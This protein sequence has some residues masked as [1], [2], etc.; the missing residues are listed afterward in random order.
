MAKTGYTIDGNLS[1]IQQAEQA[2]TNLLKKAT[3]GDF[4]AT[5]LGLF[6]SNL[7]YDD[8]QRLDFIPN[9]YRFSLRMDSPNIAK[10]TSVINLIN[11]NNSSPDLLTGTINLKVDVGDAIL[12]S[13]A[14]TKTDN[15]ITNIS[16][17]STSTDIAEVVLTRGVRNGE[18]AFY[19]PANA[20]AGTSSTIP[21]GFGGNPLSVQPGEANYSPGTGVFTLGT[22]LTY[23]FSNGDIIS[24]IREKGHDTPL[25]TSP[26]SMYPLQISNYA[27]K[28]NGQIQ[29]SLS[30]VRQDETLAGRV[31]SP[32]RFSLNNF[33]KR[34]TNSFVN[35]STAVVNNTPARDYTDLIFQTP[36]ILQF[37][38]QLPV[39]ADN[40]VNWVPPL[41]R[42]QGGPQ[43]SVELQEGLLPGR[44]SYT[45]I[46][47]HFE[48]IST[49]YNLGADRIQVGDS[50]G[51]E[52]AVIAEAY[53]SDNI[54]TYKD[55]L[56]DIESR[57]E[58]AKVI[59]KTRFTTDSPFLN[60]TKDL[61][62]IDGVLVVQDGGIPN[63][64]NSPGTGTIAGY[65]G[66][67][68]CPLGPAVYI[69][70]KGKYNR[71]FSTFDC[72]SD[73]R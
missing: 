17:S 43:T 40:F 33:S 61:I 27:I 22:D 67:D 44:G 35:P 72:C 36:S 10:D 11:A 18:G 63:G 20:G 57:I 15:F 26:A 28:R 66:F 51:D 65:A 13:P 38:R 55:A 71:A 32:V 16:R 69:K 56:D 45:N 21:A 24:A 59:S 9:N 64:K 46:Y 68:D 53:K 41:M 47:E 6:Q 3:N 58:Y 23:A 30:R 70:E 37:T 12:S 54:K 73:I 62:V 8:N 39:S 60:D 52:D 19:S 1:E 4:T 49:M 2:I 14:S 25:D 5:D 29:F 31:E 50:Y 48:S 42:E 7:R 34:R